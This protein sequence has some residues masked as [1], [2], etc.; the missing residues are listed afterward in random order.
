MYIQSI[1]YFL[2][3]VFLILGIAV[4]VVILVSLLRFRASA[5]A[6]Q[7]R[8]REKMEN[9]FKERTFLSLI[10]LIGLVIKWVKERRNRE[11]S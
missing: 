7:K 4:M 8:T 9:I 5:Q 11:T 6:F 3:S 10:P 1:F 2:A